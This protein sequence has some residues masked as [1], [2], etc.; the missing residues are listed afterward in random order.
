MAYTVKQLAKISGIS[1]RTLHWYDEIGLLK[2]AYHGANGY[3]YYEEEHMHLLRQILFFRE[4]G[5]CLYDIQKLLSKNNE[6]K[7]LALQAHR[8]KLEADIERKNEL[9]STID[10]T[11]LNLQNEQEII[12]EEV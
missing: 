7:V 2:P 12:S 6:E 8:K 11:I 10:Q 4:L 9:L 5:L 3:R 1:I